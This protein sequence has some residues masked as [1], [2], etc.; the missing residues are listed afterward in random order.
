MSRIVFHIDV[1][2]AYL[3]WEAVYR[4][5]MGSPVDLREIPSIV[6]GDREKRH[7]IVLAKSIPAKK[8]NI[9][10][11]E[12]IYLALEKCPSLVIVPPNYERYIQ[13]S[14]AM[15]EFLGAYSPS[16][17]RYS[18]DEVFMDYSN[19]D[20]AF[21]ETAE[22]IRMKIKKE[23]GFTVN[24]GI[25]P[26]K[27]LAKVA[28]DFKKPD[29]IHTLFLDEISKKM[30]PLA[31]EELFMVGSRTKKKLNSRGIFT[32]G[33][34]AGLDRDYIYSWLKKPGLLIWEFAN[35]IENSP[36]RIDSC[37]VKSVGNSTTLPFDVETKE[38]ANKV[39][40][41]ISEMIGLRIRALNMCGYVVSVS[42]KN[43]LFYSYSHQKKLVVPTD[44]TNTIYYTAKSLFHNMW[45]KEPIRHFSINLSELVSNEFFQLSLLEPLNKKN[46]DLDKTIDKL[47]LKY[48]QNSI[49]RSCFLYSGIDPIIGG[50][51]AEESYPMMS[52]IL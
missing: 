49:Q 17:Q 52:S 22:E 18:I 20:K 25:G 31:V 34:L 10:T 28:S 9:Q 8:Y 13:A 37:P 43:N 6:G 14:N 2:S 33:Q 48:G 23:L 32:I 26:N 7:G 41:A 29:N 38:E 19:M 42:I 3:S 47:R 12:S 30:W 11:G 5:Q 50:V 36:V 4:L 16:I 45:Q 46:K 21:L 24:I 27:L 1:N 15:V 51:V 40:L 44:S 35:G 39:L